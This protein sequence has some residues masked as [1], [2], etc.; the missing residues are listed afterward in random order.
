[1][2][3]GTVE[4]AKRPDRLRGLWALVLVL[5]N[6]EGGPGVL[7]RA[8]AKGEVPGALAGRLG[9]TLLL[10]AGEVSARAEGDKFDRRSTPPRTSPVLVVVLLVAAEVEVEKGGLERV[11]EPDVAGFILLQG[12]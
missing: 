4:C 5:A 9:L 3:E 12:T 7:V 11:A 8:R 1:M 2:A 10:F 6:V